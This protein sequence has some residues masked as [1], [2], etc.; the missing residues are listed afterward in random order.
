MKPFLYITKQIP[1][2]P[3]TLSYEWSGFQGDSIGIEKIYIS[4]PDNYTFK[5]NVAKEFNVK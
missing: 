1:F 3:E 4:I 5:L 2:K